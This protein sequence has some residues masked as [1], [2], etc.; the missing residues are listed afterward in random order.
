MNVYIKVEVA[1]RDLES[2]LLLGLVAA[3]R[4]HEVFIGPAGVTTRLAV[5]G[6]LQPGII[7][8]KS[9]T[10]GVRRLEELRSYRDLGFKCTSQD[11]ESGIL[12]ADYSVFA[13]MRFSS[14]SIE[15]ADSIFTW[16]KH[17]RD[18]LLRQYAEVKGVKKKL[19]GTGSP[20]VDMWRPECDMFYPRPTKRGA[21]DYVLVVS[22]FGAI[23]GYDP[24]WQEVK[25]ARDTGY[26][27]RGYDVITE[28]DR[29]G[30]KM[31]L[32][33][34][35]VAALKRLASEHPNIDFIFRPHPIE[36]PAAWSAYIG[37]IPN[38]HIVNSGSVSGWIRH[39]R[40]VIH[41]GCTTALEAVTSGKIVI[42]YRPLISK[43]EEPFPNE[44]S[45]E[46]FSEDQ[47]S[48]TLRETLE[49]AESQSQQI[50]RSGLA[51]VA[52]RIE[53]L[54]GRFASDKI[55]DHWEMLESPE[56]GKTNSVI[57]LSLFEFNYR[58]RRRVNSLLN[59]RAGSSRDTRQVESFKFP[60]MSNADINELHS[61]FKATLGRFSNVRVRVRGQYLIHLTSKQASRNMSTRASD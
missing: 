57:K 55:V 8:E 2:R 50:D 48:S 7:H 9:V 38:V 40:V 10:P 44:A 11:E 28:I 26:T 5:K 53:S 22:N 6:Y 25:F 52:R 30:Y 27:D 3:E 34:K 4:G 46:V 12:E 37:T 16:G 14:E 61:R 56:L 58:L 51:I 45:A 41:N 43:H 13:R 20:R 24:F 17:D 49:K 35:F 32:M 54:V 21:S 33:G 15:L 29:N 47:L 36:D 19:V 59:R 42:A 18:S 1:K 23:A 31:Q 39:A 60:G